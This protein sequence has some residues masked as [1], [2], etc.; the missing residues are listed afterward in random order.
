MK[1][2]LYFSV[3]IVLVLSFA[4]YY[5]LRIPL[6]NLPDVVRVATGLGAK[7]ACSSRYIS[8]FSHERIMNDLAS[9]SSANRLV[10]LRYDDGN[11]RVTAT[12]WGMG[13]K[14]ALYRDG[15]GCTLENGDA[16]LRAQPLQPVGAAE[17]QLKQVWPQGHEVTTTSKTWQT[18][19]DTMLRNDNIAGRHTRALIIVKNGK[20][21]AESY[22]KGI[23]QNTPLLGWSMGKSVTAML[24]GNLVMNNQLSLRDDQLFTS[25]LE[26]ERADVNI[27]DLLT[28]TSGLGFDETYA[29]G[30]DATHMLFHA[31]SASDVAMRAPLERE[32]GKHFSYS[33]GT[34][35]LLSRI[36]YAHTGGDLSANLAYLHQTLIA[37]LNL[38]HLLFEVDASGVFVGSSYIYATSRDWAKLGLLMLN[39]GEING[40]RVYSPAFAHQMKTPNA[41]INERRYGYQVWLNS[42]GEAKRW[43]LLPEDAYAMMGS[44]SQIVMAIPSE[45]MVIVRLGWSKRRYPIDTQFAHLIKKGREKSLMESSR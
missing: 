27:E 4:L 10:E 40:H 19:T 3:A 21:V 1:K 36:I 42:G 14:N 15:I 29:P 44:R 16:P 39:N 45:D 12:L 26:D 32:P 30:S 13:E 9:Y 18:L 43:P 34:T 35:N 17:Q 31:P 20:I 22:G 25:W 7:I 2:L 23:D 37:P 5:F 11:K 6:W 38:R 8:N 28:M 33:S 24:I 41:S